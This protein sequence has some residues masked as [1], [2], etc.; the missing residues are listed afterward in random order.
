MNLFAASAGTLQVTGLDRLGA[1]NC[2]EFKRLVQ[3]HLT[4]NIRVVELDCTH[5]RF[6]DSDGLGT[7]ITIHK[8]LAGGA[9]RVRLR[10]PTPAVLS[11][12]RLMRL[13]EVFEITP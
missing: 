1:S 6:I 2:D 4:E 12:L 3:P 5:L 8:R 11:L 7:L 10:Q 13:D 9:G